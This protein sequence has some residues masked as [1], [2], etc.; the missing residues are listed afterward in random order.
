MDT[1]RSDVRVGAEHDVATTAM[2]AEVERLLTRLVGHLVRVLGVDLASIIVLRD[3]TE[4][5][6]VAQPSP[7]EADRLILL[8]SLDDGPGR[9]AMVTG[10]TVMSGNLLLEHRWARYRPVALQAGYEAVCALPMDVDDR[11]IGVLQLCRRT[12]R[13][14]GA[15][16]LDA[17]QSLVEPTAGYLLAQHTLQEQQRTIEHL[18]RRD[19]MLQRRRTE[20][21]TTA[22]PVTGSGTPAKDPDRCPSSSA[23]PQVDTWDVDPEATFLTWLADPQALDVLHTDDRQPLGLPV[24]WLLG[25]LCVSSTPLSEQTARQLGYRRP[26]SIGDAATDLLLAVSDPG[27]PRCS[28]FAAARTYLREFAGYPSGAPP[29]T[30][31]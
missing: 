15:H 29:S 11:Q 24:S 25:M 30:G 26:S 8:R 22:A 7:T 2:A 12:A 20:S 19:P 5:Q 9:D 1:P 16:E 6:V 27:G 14:W 31:T 13:P 21:L 17:A 3:G 4:P 28:S 23:P 10:D 18:Q